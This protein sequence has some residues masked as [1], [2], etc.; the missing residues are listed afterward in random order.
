MPLPLILLGAAAIAGTTGV[1]AGAKGVQKISEAKDRVKAADDRYEI[2]KKKLHLNESSTMESLD[3]LGASKVQIWKDFER[4]SVAFEKI[5]NRPEF[6]TKLND[7]FKLPKHA[8]NAIKEIQIQ[9]VEILGTTAASAGAGALTGMAAYSGVMALGTAS[10]GTAISTLSGAAA[11]KAA[12][13]ALG[14]GSIASGGGGIALGT[15]V[16]GGAVAGPIIAVG[17]LLLNAKGNSSIE[18]AQEAEKEVEK[19]VKVIDES[20]DFLSKLKSLCFTLRQELEKTQKVYIQQVQQLEKLVSQK[21]DYRTYTN[22]ER[23]IVDNN[24]KIVGILY[25]LSMQ[26]LLD[27]KQKENNNPKILNDNVNNLIKEVQQQR[28]QVA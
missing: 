6:E 1:V 7:T 26:N 4:F 25:R 20:C 19:I 14:G 11:T 23:Q 22:E 28:S 17:G 24:I 27:D 15:Q 16:L 13:A 3:K 9:A 10:T 2:A 12:L 18:K 8:L 5:Q 21:V